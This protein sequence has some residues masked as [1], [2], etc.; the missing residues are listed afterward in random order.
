VSALTIVDTDILIDVARRN[1]EAIECLAQLE[2]K[3]G[4]AVSVITQMELLVG[5]RNKTEQQKTER[6]LHRFRVLKLTESVSDVAID[7]ICHYRLS[8]GLAIPDSLIAATSI[9]WNQPLITKNQRD[10]SFINGLDLLPYPR[11]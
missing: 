1:I 10:Y 3:T 2:Q 11:Q 7:L 4:L 9:V 6:F 8:H 5:C